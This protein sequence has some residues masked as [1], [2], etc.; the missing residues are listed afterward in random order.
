[1]TAYNVIRNDAILV[2]RHYDDVINSNVVFFN[3]VNT[4]SH[5]KFGVPMR[6][7]LCFRYF[8]GFDL[9]LYCK[10][11]WSNAPCKIGLNLLLT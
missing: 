1:M 7:G 9:P 5:A 10:T 6:F 8:G 4:S 2:W 11:L 3:F